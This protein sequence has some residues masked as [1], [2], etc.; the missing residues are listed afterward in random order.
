MG[1]VRCGGYLTWWK[2]DMVEIWNGGYNKQMS[3][4]S[5]LKGDQ[6]YIKWKK[7]AIWHSRNLMW[8]KFD[9]PWQK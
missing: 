3:Q 7:A 6:E 9:I 8:L 1:E 4:G 2:F 5:N